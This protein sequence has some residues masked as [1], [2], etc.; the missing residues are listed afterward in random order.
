MSPNYQDEP[1]DL[2]GEESECG[3]GDH[4]DSE[5]LE[6]GGPDNQDDHASNGAE[7]GSEVAKSSLKP[8]GAP[9]LK[10]AYWEFIHAEQKKIQKA[11]PEMTPKE[12]LSMARERPLGSCLHKCPKTIFLGKAPKKNLKSAMHKGCK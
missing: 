6:L 10:S 5:T 1:E 8:D 2:E 9:N 4:L 7:D 12:V 3:S 11:N